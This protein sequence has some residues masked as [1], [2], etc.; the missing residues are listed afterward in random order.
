MNNEENTKKEWE[1]IVKIYEALKN[2]DV[3]TRR[4]IMDYV[5]AKIRSERGS[6]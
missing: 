6:D 5:N 4:R 2:F 1:S 3:K